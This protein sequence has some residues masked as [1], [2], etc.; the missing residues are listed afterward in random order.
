MGSSATGALTVSGTPCF[1]DNHAGTLWPLELLEDV[2]GQGAVEVG[3]DRESAGAQTEG[4]RLGGDCRQGPDL[5]QRTLALYDDEGFS[6]LDA[7]E[8]GERVTLDILYADGAHAIIV[9]GKRGR[10]SAASDEE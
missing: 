5:R 1:P 3:G 6:R 9:T 2:V 4:A 7:P 10:T 8:E